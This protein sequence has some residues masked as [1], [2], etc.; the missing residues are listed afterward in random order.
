MIGVDISEPNTPPLEMVKVPPFI[1]SILSVPSLA[2]LPKSPIVFSIPRDRQL[3]GVA[4]HR[5]D[6]ALRRRHRD[7]DVGIIVIDDLVA[8]DL[9]R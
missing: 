4:D 5:H 8:V 6:E 3:V 1:S 7:R 2:R 9:A